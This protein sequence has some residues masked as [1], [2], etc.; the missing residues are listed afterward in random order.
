M[1]ILILVDCYIPSRKSAARLIQ[2]LACELVKQGHNPVVLTPNA[3][4][5]DSI[6]IINENGIEIIRVRTGRIKGVNKIFRALNEMLLP[7]N[8]WRH[9]R[10]YFQKNRCEHIIFYSPTIF[11]GPLVKY[12]KRRWS[13]R[14][15]LILRDIFPQWA[16]DVGI[17]KP[18][19][20]SRFFQL[21]EHNQYSAADVIGVQSSADL[22]YFD[23]KKWSNGL[24]LEVLYNWAPLMQ[25]DVS[26]TNYRIELGL[27]GKVVFFYGGNMGVAQDMDKILQ[28]AE[29][30]KNNK[31]VFFLLVGEGSLISYMQQVIKDRKMSN[32]MIHESVSQKD[33]FGMLREFD[34]GLL[35]LNHNLKTHNFPGKLLGYMQFG[36]PILAWPNRGNEICKFLSLNEAAL[37][38]ESENGE[39]EM[40]AYA[41]LLAENNMIRSTL[42]RN[43]RRLLEQNYS[44]NVI[45]RQLLGH[46]ISNKNNESDT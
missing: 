3:E 39:D 24:I 22:Q 46:A 5:E 23:G 43:A 16:I 32:I 25:D 31:D 44:V 6:D 2:D 29:R 27:K 45:A 15:Y 33:Y 26:I 40:V 9:T 20:I 42:G 11:W 17:L 21:A 13:C 37:V 28:L 19:L 4:I 14:S 10:K 34:V 7:F 38:V 18:G 12:L 41:E 30:L 8:L 35:T 1:R 36:L